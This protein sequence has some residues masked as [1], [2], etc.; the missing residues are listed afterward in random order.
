VKLEKVQTF[1]KKPTQKTTPTQKKFFFE[2]VH[3]LFSLFSSQVF[4]TCATGMAILYSTLYNNGRSHLR[5]IFS[6]DKF[7]K[8]T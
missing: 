3:K 5:R 2:K 8:I 6:L 7:I 1:L 4:R